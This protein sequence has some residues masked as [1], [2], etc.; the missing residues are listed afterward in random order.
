MTSIQIIRLNTGEDIV[1]YTT[2]LENGMIEVTNPMGVRMQNRGGHETSIILYHWLPIQIVEIN[3]VDL[4]LKDVLFITVPTPA[5][6]EYYMNTVE[7]VQ[8]LFEAKYALDEVERGETTVAE[9]DPIKNL[10]LEQFQDME[11]GNEDIKH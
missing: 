6:E 3:S 4:S 2:E 11:F 5:F 1:G 8:K 10:I 9:S 7:K